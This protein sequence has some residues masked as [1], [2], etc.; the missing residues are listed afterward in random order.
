MKK[1]YIIAVFMLLVLASAAAGD[2]AGKNSGLN[3]NND[4]LMGI[5]WQQNSGEYAAL[6]YQAFNAG[7]E[8]LL[9]LGCKVSYRAKVVPRPDWVPPQMKATPQKNFL[10]NYIWRFDI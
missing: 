10:E 5:L 1:N 8:Y 7:K 9:S 4:L 2:E 6:C 3:F